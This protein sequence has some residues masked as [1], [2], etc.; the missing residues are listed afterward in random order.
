[1]GGIRLRPMVALC[2]RLGVLVFV[3]WS[4]SS[5]AEYAADH[6][7]EQANNYYINGSFDIALLSINKSLEIDP[8]NIAAWMIKGDSFYAFGY[9]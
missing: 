5:G 1:L 7:L 2:L 9:V 6:W 3:S 8:L 4:L